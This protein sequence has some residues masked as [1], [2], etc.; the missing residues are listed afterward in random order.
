MRH[1]ILAA[2]GVATLLGAG[3]AVAG[4]QG[5]APSL[6]HLAR[7]VVPPSKAYVFPAVTEKTFANG[8]R[9]VVLE[10]HDL[11]LV[12]VRTVLSGGPL[13]DPSGKEGT[14][15]LLRM[16]LN[17][18]TTN[19]PAA[20]LGAEFADLGSVVNDSGF[21]TTTANVDSSL[22]VLADLLRHPAFA[23][24]SLERARAQRVDLA[25]RGKL[26][27]NPVTSR[28]M[29]SVLYGASHPYARFE[30]EQSLAA[31]TRDDIVALHA[32][33]VRPPNV[34]LLMVGDVTPASAFA[35]AERWFGD[36]PRGTGSTLAD[37]HLSTG[38]FAPPA[39]AIYLVD[40]P[41]PTTYIR[42]A[43]LS[44]TRTSPD[45][46]A[47]DVLNAIYGELSGS[48]LFKELREKRK[49][50]YSTRSSFLW[51]PSPMPSTLVTTVASV[52][53]G[54]ADSAVM[55]LIGELRG[56]AG[57]R[58]P[59]ADEFD[60]G[61][62]NRIQSLPLQLETHERMA[63]LLSEIVQQNLPYDFITRYAAGL[64]TVT[65]GQLTAVAARDIDPA[66]TAIIVVGDAKVL[67]PKLR[68][69]NIA[70]V[71]IVDDR[72]VRIR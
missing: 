12:V 64:Q 27:G 3:R 55:S 71:Y 42:M 63:G 70:P 66:H 39:T 22:A 7:P 1:T 72:G 24:A 17:D 47:L 53:N 51:R 8:L 31:I 18:A 23:P 50:T 49:L 44:A 21:V 62:Q 60:F 30:S 57:A 14:F 37:L 40:A 56:I 35:R 2:L 25:T 33:W 16:L 9:V 54:Q 20:T 5:A 68:A 52:P 29:A 28:V 43:G 46:A 36:W 69:A 38:P 41:S 48:R 11:P 10:R 26:A 65:P 58:P 67:E 15:G 19:R 4:A 13:A 34:T 61:K 59:S 32:S 45:L 6:P